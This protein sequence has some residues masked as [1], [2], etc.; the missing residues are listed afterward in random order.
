MY[1]YIDSNVIVSAEI[2]F[3]S[4][5]SQSKAFM[6]FAERIH[7][8]FPDV[9]FAT[10]VFTF[11]ELASA[12]IRRTNSE[13]KTLAL[14]YRVSTRWQ[15]WI[16]PVAPIDPKKPRTFKQLVD[17]LVVTA[18]K[19]HTPSADTLHAQTIYLYDF[20]YLV[21]W[22]KKDFQG[23]LKEMKKL[24]IL[25]PQEMYMRLRHLSRGRTTKTVPPGALS[26]TRAEMEN[27][28]RHLR[29]GSSA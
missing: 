20:D 23:M 22:N 1:I 16:K 12:M 28:M 25:T 18:V 21:T 17:S 27:I 5:H 13:D 11:L 24:T 7:S 10:S 4:T 3:E 2:P 14:L 6:E 15:S 29:E 19:F 8:R 26:K 9:K